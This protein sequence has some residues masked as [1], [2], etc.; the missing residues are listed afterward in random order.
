MGFAVTE[1]HRFTQEYDDYVQE[2]YPKKRNFDFFSQ[3]AV[4]LWTVRQI[5][6]EDYIDRENPYRDHILRAWKKAQSGDKKDGYGEMKKLLASHFVSPVVQI[7]NYYFKEELE[8]LRCAI[9]YSD[10]IQH[11]LLAQVLL[12]QLAIER[13]FDFAK[14]ELVKLIEFSF[15]ESDFQRPVL[16][17]RVIFEWTR[18]ACFILVYCRKS[19]KT[20]FGQNL[21]L[22]LSSRLSILKPHSYEF[23]QAI[24]WNGKFLFELGKYSDSLLWFKKGVACLNQDKRVNVNN[25]ILEMSNCLGVALSNYNLGYCT[26]A[27]NQARI[28]KV[29]CLQFLGEYHELTVE[30]SSL[31]TKSWLWSFVM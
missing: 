12:T 25:M 7:V 10:V 22:K 11:R 27:Y 23:C 1:D 31:V 17:P 18:Q 15:A 4:D 26:E 28:V 9:E 19:G 20:E 6:L 21:A 14:T 24:Y 8:E 2:Q 3:N 30:S 29:E 16:N 13:G 5:Y